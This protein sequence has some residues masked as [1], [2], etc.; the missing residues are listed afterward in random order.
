MTQPGEHPHE[1]GGR[2]VGTFVVLMVAVTI[3]AVL[4]AMIIPV[5]PTIQHELGT[6]A[7]EVSWV[8]SAYLMAAAVAMPVVGRLGDVHGKKRILVAVLALTAIGSLIAAFAPDIIVMIIARIIQGVGG[9]IVPLSLG[10]VRDV[11][12][13]RH[14]PR[15][16][17]ALSALGGI[18]AGIGL[19]L[20][21][22]I[23]DVLG[24]RWLFLAPMLLTVLTVIAA[25]VVLPR[26]P[27]RGGAVSWLPA[28][29]LG[30]ML[31]AFLLATTQATSWGW[32][33]LRTIGAY[34]GCVLF[35]A[36]WLAAERRVRHPLIDPQLLVAPHLRSANLVGFL[37]GFAMFGVYAYVPQFLQTPRSAGYGFDATVLQSGLVL[38][39]MVL[40]VFAGGLLA[41]RL[42]RAFGART[43]VVAASVVMA[44]GLAA[45]TV[46]RSDIWAVTAILAVYG[47]AL[48][49]NLAS[50]STIVVFAA[51][52][53]ATA[54]ASAINFN[55]RNIGGAVGA[56][57]MATIVTADLLDG[58]LPAEG[59]Y[60][61]GFLVFAAAMV[62]AA[63]LALTI[64]RG[65]HLPQPEVSLR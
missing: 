43:V 55:L 56:A 33:D 39:P 12:P 21:G 8:L 64:P 1:G 57:A 60:L 31:V 35:G 50:L 3:F 58:G 23:V 44:L 59:G 41:S 24:Y 40:A 36:I 52:R 6:S 10:I 15:A 29:F 53:A 27:G 16:V 47:L 49:V 65:S 4:Q 51:P 45:L 61:V 17:G 38:T 2:L 5:L 19:V 14:T 22:P 30:A 13:D 18:G 62:A 11:F 7:R 20:A 63:A 28:P 37:L 54:V 46:G 48:G 42:E 32:L 34:A 26:S 9:A 25:I